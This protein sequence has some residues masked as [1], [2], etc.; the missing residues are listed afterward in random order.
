VPRRGRS[1]PPASR[2]AGAH[3]HRPRA[4]A[5]PAPGYAGRA[6]PDDRRR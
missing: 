5:L 3:L 6:R 1:A 2:G 4:P